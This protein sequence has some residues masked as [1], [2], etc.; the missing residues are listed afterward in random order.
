MSPLFKK[1]KK[2]E[3]DNDWFLPEES[4]KHLEEHFGSLEAPVTLVIFTQEGENDPYNEYI[5]K[6]ADDLSRLS[7]KITIESHDLDSDIAREHGVEASPTVLFNPDTYDIRFRGAPLG[8]EGRSFINT[9]FLVSLGRS[10]LSEAS[11]N[12]LAELDEERTVQVFVNPTCP[13]CPGQVTNAVRC[14]IE[15]PGLIRAE[16]VEAGENPELAMRHNV[17]SVPHTEF[18]GLD[19]ARHTL[20]GY[21][22]EERF[23]VEMV[24]LKDAEELAHELGG[25]S[26]AGHGPVVEV[27]LAIIGA[28][29]AGLTAGIY[30]ERAGLRTVVLEKGLVGGQVT[31]TPVVENYPGFPTVPGKQLMDIM[32]QHAREYVTILEGEDVSEIKIGRNVE[33]LTNRG[34]YV[35]KG[36]VLATGATYSQLGA[37]GEERYFGKG[38][39]YCASCDGYLF[40]QKK[41]AIIGGGNTALTDALHLKNLGVDVTIIHRRDTFRA[42][43]HLQESVEREGIHV[44]WN[45]VVEEIQGD[46]KRVTGLIVRNVKD[47]SVTE[48]PVNGAFVAIGQKANTELA[49]MVGL[50]LNEQGFVQV[51]AAMRTNIPRIYAAGDITGGVQQIVTA[52]GEGSVA[53]MSAFEDISHP[54]WKK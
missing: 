47:D 37:P 7:E 45:T 16:C 20:L 24:T 36:L 14:A 4:R 1:D 51:D 18:F 31:L 10:G 2:K 46:E 13:Y 49:T 15:K 22:P 35:A 9:L 5:H 42:Q 25:H 38:V 17:G 26:H 19:D 28:G 23:V 3:E 50:T 52:I 33:V 41:V 44:L 21:V 29:P 39:N 48:L 30:A 8:E 54:Y 32:S 27:D 40:K 6:F 43:Q 34:A 12:L 53:A 11:R